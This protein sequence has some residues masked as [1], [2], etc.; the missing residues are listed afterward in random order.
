MNLNEFD[1]ETKYDTLILKDYNGDSKTIDID[2]NNINSP[3]EKIKILSY[4][5]NF[6]QKAK[7]TFWLARM[8]EFALFF[9]FKSGILIL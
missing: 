9:Y 3:I 2:L 7:K 8:D 4:N 6:Q 1:Y 5:Q